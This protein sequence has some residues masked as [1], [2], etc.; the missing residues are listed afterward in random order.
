VF[1]CGREDLRP[2]A[3]VKPVSRGPKFPL[4]LLLYLDSCDAAGLFIA[5][6]IGRGRRDVDGSAS[7][8]F[9]RAEMPLDRGD[10]LISRHRPFPDNTVPRFDRTTKCGVGVRSWVMTTHSTRTAISIP[11]F[12]QKTRIF[13]AR[14]RAPL[15]VRLSSSGGRGIGQ[16][17]H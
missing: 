13:S 5:R 10:F 17:L 9:V 2:K 8:R 15:S 16:Q 7:G 11:C 3:Q 12:C 6:E 1:C 14:C 4:G